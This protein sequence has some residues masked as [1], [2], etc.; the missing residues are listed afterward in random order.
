MPKPFRFVYASLLIV[1][2]LYSVFVT[3]HEYPMRP[4]QVIT[5]LIEAAVLF[6]LVRSRSE[7]PAW[8]FW[9]ALA[10]GVGLFAIRFT[11]DAAWWTGHLFYSLD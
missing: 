6:G 7:I 8:L 10:C 9:I 3:A 4:E 1:W 2:F 5:M 11:G